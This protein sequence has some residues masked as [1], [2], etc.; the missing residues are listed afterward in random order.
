MTGFAQESSTQREEIVGG[1]VF[2]YDVQGR[3]VGIDIEYASQRVERI[4]S[5]MR[6][7]AAGSVAASTSSCQVAG[8]FPWRS[9][10]AKTA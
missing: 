8:G 1:I 2:D 10:L 9:I 7:S 6:A 4:A 5:L 3:L